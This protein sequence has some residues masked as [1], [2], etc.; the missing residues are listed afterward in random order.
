MKKQ[1]LF[2]LLPLALVACVSAPKSSPRAVPTAVPGVSADVPRE[3]TDL[4]TD[5]EATYEQILLRAESKGADAPLVDA[6]AAL[7]MPVPDHRTVRSAISLFSNSMKPSIQESFF[8]S[9]EYKEMIDAVLD[10]YR[11]P[12]GL[13][14]LPVIESAYLPLLT[15]KAGA[16]GIWQFMPDTAREY[17]LRVDWWVD[18]RTD[19]EKSTRA[20][21]QM[22]RQLHDRFGDWALALAAYNCGP[23][24]VSRTLI[25]HNV[26]SFWDLLE[27]GALPKET[28]GYVPTFFAT[29]TLVSDPVTYGFELLPAKSTDVK[30]VEVLG[31]VSLEYIAEV[32]GADSKQVARLNPQFRRGVLPPGRSSVRLPE[33]LAPVLEARAATIRHEDPLVEV[34]TFTLR[35]G[36][37][38][39]R[40]AK[41]LKT[42]KDD[43]L[44]MNGLKNESVRP[45][46]SIYLPVRKAELSN[47]LRTQRQPADNYYVVE[48]GDTLYSIAKRHNLTVEELTDLN[49][50]RDTALQPGMRLRVSLSSTLSAGGM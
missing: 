12:R 36:D 43:I 16:R 18:E 15:S 11:L 19:P 38:L 5:L 30:R 37:S 23:G 27:R 46:D 24:R 8:R 32:I 20:A 1:F 35:S 44:K 14:Y 25:E 40:L 2:S 21:A 47:I 50:L 33:K 41:T 6:D 26:T 3:I 45:G 13:A 4:R 39:A 7:S 29:L 31:P 49:Q 10:E 48:K 9:A 17:G 34:A 28:R 42:S 22:L